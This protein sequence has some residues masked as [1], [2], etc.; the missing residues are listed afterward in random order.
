VTP[1]QTFHPNFKNMWSNLGVR[2]LW[3]AAAAYILFMALG[4]GLA[5]FTA[6]PSTCATCHEI[7]PAVESWKTSPHAQVGCPK[8]HQPVTS[9]VAFPATLVWRGQMLQRDVTAHR[10]NPLASKLTTVQANSRPVPD[11]NCLQCHDLTRAVTLPNGLVMDHAKHVAR[12]RSCVSCHYFTAHPVPDAQKQLVLMARCFQCHGRQPGAKAPGT[13]TECHPASFNMRPE[14]HTPSD[15][16]L[17]EHGKIAK[18]DRKPC[19]MCHDPK[20]CND[21]HV[22]PM[23]HPAGWAA[24]PNPLHAAVA[25]QDPKVCERCHG[26]APNLCNMCHHKGF[27]PKSGPWA[28]H[29]APTVSTFGVPF[30]LSCHDEL[31]C[32]TCHAREGGPATPPQ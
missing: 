1:S 7:A 9:W 32:M 21:C 31:F 8:C 2:L 24:R 19:A 13:C 25:K 29:H 5:S 16:W 4:A 30:C 10:A 23:P 26:P 18:V 17:A 11:E 14:S 12:N 15:R 22:L 28:S 27:D 3:I 20:F 6:Q